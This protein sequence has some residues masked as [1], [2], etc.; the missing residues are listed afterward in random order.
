MRATVAALVVCTSLMHAR[1]AK[2]APFELEWSAPEGCPS[3]ERIVTASLARLGESSSSAPPELYVHGT[4]TVEDGVIAAEFRLKDT[5]GA[6]LGERRVRFDEPRCEDIVEST[7]LVLAMMIAVARPHASAPEPASEPEAR[8][9]PPPPPARVGRPLPPATPER[10]RMHVPMTLGASAVAS[11]GLL[12]N[13]GFGGALRWT[14][15]LSPVVVGVEGSFETS[16]SV[17]VLGAEA[18]FRFVDAA[19]LVGFRVMRARWLELIPIVE[20]RGGIAVASTTGFR[21][22]YDATRFVGVIAAGML[23]RIPL[24][25]ALRLEVLPDVRVPLNADDFMVSDRGKLYHVHRPASVEGR[26]AV[27]FG[28]EFP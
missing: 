8:S 11:V 14:A 4:V 10:S 3:G 9:A 28:W 25:P 23:G 16:Q 18:K 12:P 22:A 13:I 1:F 7:A 6:D 17:R 19:A 21:S 20:A 24:G 15:T 2:A 5:R 26:L 27:G